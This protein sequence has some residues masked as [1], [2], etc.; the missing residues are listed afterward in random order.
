MTDLEKEIDR[1][2]RENAELHARL[3]WR[4]EQFRLNQQRRFVA[5]SE[6]SDDTQL[7]LF[8]EAESEAQALLAEPTVNDNRKVDH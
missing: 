8:N 2:R 7:Q 1:L 5:S 3:K 6:P 4:E